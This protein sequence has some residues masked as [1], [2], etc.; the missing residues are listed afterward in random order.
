MHHAIFIFIN[1]SMHAYI[2]ISVG[3][4]DVDEIIADL[5]QAL[6]LISAYDLNIMIEEVSCIILSDRLY[7][8]QPDHAYIHTYKRWH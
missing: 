7:F 6:D 4:E 5:T 8:H 1:Q 2:H 3:I